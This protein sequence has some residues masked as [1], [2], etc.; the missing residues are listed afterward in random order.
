MAHLK[1]CGDHPS[2]MEARVNKRLQNSGD[3]KHADVVVKNGDG[4][5]RTFTNIHHS[6]NHLAPRDVRKKGA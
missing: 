2:S 1:L 5:R 3:A 4:A 6:A